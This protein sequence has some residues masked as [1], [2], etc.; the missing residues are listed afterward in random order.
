DDRATTLEI[1]P[2]LPI[3]H[4]EK[5]GA[6]ETID[7]PA[8]TACAVDQSGIAAEIDELP[9][10]GALAEKRRS[11]G[12]HA[13]PY[14]AAHQSSICEEKLDALTGRTA[15]SSAWQATGARSA[16]DSCRSPHCRSRRSEPGRCD[17]RRTS[18][19]STGSRCRPRPR[20][21]G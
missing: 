9:A 12:V 6:V 21:G 14:V 11:R 19:A 16:R 7:F 1:V 2:L 4:R 20:T 18:R 13:I 17:P 15:V 8:D 5:F 10:H 3:E